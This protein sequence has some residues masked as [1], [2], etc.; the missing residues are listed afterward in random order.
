MSAFSVPYGRKEKTRLCRYA[1][2]EQGDLALHLELELGR[3]SRTIKRVREA[4][5]A[6]RLRIEDGL[7]PGNLN[8]FSST[9][10][11]RPSLIDRSSE[12]SARS[13]RFASASAS[14]G[15][16]AFCS[17][18]QTRRRWSSPLM[19]VSPTLTI[20]RVPLAWISPDCTD[21]TQVH[22]KNPPR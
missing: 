12:A 4:R 14:A 18:W 16:L 21:G 8:G 15:M 11:G 10:S 13:A 3:Q 20:L 7:Q 2:Y 6:T 19:R 5:Y 1:Y 9:R 22:S 17:M